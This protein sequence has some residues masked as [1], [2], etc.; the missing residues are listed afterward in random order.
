MVAGSARCVVSLTSE[1]EGEEVGNRRYYPVR[2]ELEGLR[3]RHYGV[4]RRPLR[5]EEYTVL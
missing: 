1:G 2:R 3:G 4:N 5:V